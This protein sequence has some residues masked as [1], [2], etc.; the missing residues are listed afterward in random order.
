[1]NS[2]FILFIWDLP[3]MSIVQVY[4]IFTTQSDK[5]LQNIG[6]ILYECARTFL[7]HSSIEI[8]MN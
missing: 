4:S 5:S 6:P 8:E 1:M 7:Q 3:L 2:H